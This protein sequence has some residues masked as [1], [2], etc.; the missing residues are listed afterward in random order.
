[1]EPVIRELDL[2]DLSDLDLDTAVERLLDDVAAPGPVGM[3]PVKSVLGR[4]GHA[5][6][7]DR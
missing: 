3:G 1:M 7:R 4:D 5:K 2:A 6:R